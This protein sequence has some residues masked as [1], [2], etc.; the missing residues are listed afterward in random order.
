MDDYLSTIDT[1]GFSSTQLAVLKILREE[2]AK[3]PTEFDKTVLAYTEGFEEL[4][5]A[6]FISW[7]FNEADTPF[8]HQDTGYW[9]IPGVETLQ[10]YY[11]QFG[12]YYD[13]DDYEPQFGDVA[14][15]FGET[16]D[17]S[18]TEHV[19]IVLAVKDNTLIT[20]GG[21]ETDAGIVQIRADRLKEGA[22]GLSGF[23][24]SDLE[25]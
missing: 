10:E 8:I 12:A 21:N 9:R 19:A 7:V 13:V 24:A 15:Y 18:S 14:F 16:P 2:Y 25:I 22:E 20:I 17:G 4:W 5:C 11:R 3:H 1:T 6:D 23:G